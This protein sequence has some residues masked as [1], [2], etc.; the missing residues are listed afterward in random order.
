LIIEDADDDDGLRENNNDFVRF[1][2]K[3]NYGAGIWNMDGKSPAQ[4][5]KMN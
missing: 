3:K 1:G 4:W 5:G 2:R